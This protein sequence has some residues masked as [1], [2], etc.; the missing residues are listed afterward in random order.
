MI[1]LI[2]THKNP[3][4]PYCFKT[5]LPDYKQHDVD[6]VVILLSQGFE[7]LK[8]YDDLPYLVNCLQFY[9][10]CEGDTQKL[11][12]DHLTLKL[13]L[14]NIPVSKVGSRLAML[15]ESISDMPSTYLKYFQYVHRGSAVSFLNFIIIIIIIF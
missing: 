6:R 12:T 11:L 8:F 15:Q 5:H 2:S 9:K 4:S 7:L 14:P 10:L 1:F 13:E 3:T